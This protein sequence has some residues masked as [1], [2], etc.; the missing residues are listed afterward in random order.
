MMGIGVLPSADKLGLGM[1]GV[2][3]NA[4]ANT[5]LHEADLLL[6]IGARADER[7]IPNPA[8]FKGR[9]IIHV[10]IDP[11]ELGKNILP[12]VPIVCDCK[13]FLEKLCTLLSKP[14]ETWIKTNTKPH[15]ENKL[16]PA[17]A[18]IN[19]LTALTPNAVIVAD[20]GNNQ[21]TAAMSS[22]TDRGRFITSGGMGT[23]GYALPAAIGAK[24]AMPQAE[25]I[26]VC[27]DGGFQM[28]MTELATVR[29]QKLPVKIV[30][31]N[32]SSLGMVRDLI[33]ND[34]IVWD[35]SA[36]GADLSVGNPDFA[37]IAKC[38]GITSER[39]TDFSDEAI[40]RLLDSKSAY[41]IDLIL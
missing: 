33:A 40:K 12:T 31:L 3:G 37:A 36:Y 6:F 41:L 13:F 2:F 27:G 16:T 39:V 23:M 11:A 25:V 32:D 20:V 22:V 34:T 19:K 7:A 9:E 4:Q 14:C 28:T 10:D 29:E 18:F 5:A 26:C 24:T 38:Y 21:I 30:I 1:I 17:G 15:S 8:D 35:A